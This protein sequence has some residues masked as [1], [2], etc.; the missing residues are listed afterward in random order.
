ML[1]RQLAE[2]VPERYRLLPAIADH[3]EARVAA[4]QEPENFDKEFIRL[5]YAAQ[6]Y[7]GEGEPFPMP[8]A[9]AV[10]NVAVQQ[11]P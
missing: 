3:D 6:G 9:L 4:G 5:Y 7:R 11:Q 2:E 10:P 1:V 8:Q